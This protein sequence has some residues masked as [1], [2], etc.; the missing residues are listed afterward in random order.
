VKHLKLVQRE[1]ERCTAIVRNLL[2]FARQRPLSLKDTDVVA[3]LEEAISLVGHQASLKGLTISKTVRP[4][5]L[6][7]VD[8]GQ[9]RQAIVNI[10]LNGFEAMQSGGSL[11][12]RCGPTRDGKAIELLCQDSG[13]GIPPDRL[14]KIFDPFFSTKEMGTGLGLSVVYGI[15][16][17]HGGTIDIRSAV[18]KGTTVVFRLPLV[19]KAEA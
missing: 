18:G 6:I 2:D 8:A 13:V 11:R 9:L 3:V 5:P 7:K 14:A 12:V 16:E 17:R 4:V 1:P 10:M 19:R 15:I